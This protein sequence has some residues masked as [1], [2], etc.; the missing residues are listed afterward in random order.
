MPYRDKSSRQAKDRENAYRRKWREQNPEK[1]KAQLEKQR[2]WYLRNPDKWRRVQ[3]RTLLRAYGLSIEDYER[4]Y[5]A[6]GALCAICHKPESI[7]NKLLAVDHNHITGKVRSLLCNKCNQGLGYFNE[8]IE[9]LQR[10]ID[11]LKLHEE[12]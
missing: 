3:R 2:S 10:V 5:D 9:T 4:L 7:P 1:Y 12:K 11:Y 8:N 6:Q